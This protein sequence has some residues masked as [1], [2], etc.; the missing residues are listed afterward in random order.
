MKRLEILLT[1]GQY[2]ALLN[3]AGRLDTSVFSRV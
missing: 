3:A 1:P 2:R